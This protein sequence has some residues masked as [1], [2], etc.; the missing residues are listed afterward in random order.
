MTEKLELYKCA[1]CGNIVEVVL[2]GAGELV[3]C[4]E[5]MEKLEPKTDELDDALK[6]KHIPVVNR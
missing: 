4:G 2:S 1:V 5:A 6:E 3:C